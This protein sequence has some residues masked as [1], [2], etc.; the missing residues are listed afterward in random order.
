MFDLAGGRLPGRRQVDE[1]WLTTYRGWVY[2]LGFG[3]QLG[4]GAVTVV[5]TAL[6]PALVVVGV[7]VGLAVEP[8]AGFVVGVGYGAARGLL[9]VANA[10]VRTID[11]LKTLHRRLD[12]ADERVRIGT[13]S[14]VGLLAV[15]VAGAAVTGVAA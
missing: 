6:F 13:A 11:Q 5:N 15:L 1:T 4:F 7:V 10:R 9:A 14:A 2:G 12:A 3:A 8:A